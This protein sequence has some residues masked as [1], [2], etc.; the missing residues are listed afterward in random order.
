MS[1]IGFDGVANFI[2]NVILVLLVMF[3]AAAAIWGMARFGVGVPRWLRA[4]AKG[5]TIVFSCVFVLVMLKVAALY[6][7]DR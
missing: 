7:G 2:G 4:I 5:L 6:F 3:I 1:D